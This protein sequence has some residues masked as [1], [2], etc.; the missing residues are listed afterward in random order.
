MGARAGDFKLDTSGG[1]LTYVM[2]VILIAIALYSIYKIYLYIQERKKWGWFTTLCK[3]KRLSAKE[4]TYLRQIV[5]R[6]KISSTDDLY[7]SMYQLN[8][9]TPIKKKLLFEGER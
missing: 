1:P 7:G 8:L 9:P 5:L 4:T 2:Y 3:S 6:N